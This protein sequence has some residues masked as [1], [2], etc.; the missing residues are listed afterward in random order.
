LEASRKVSMQMSS[1]FARREVPQK[2]TYRR[3]QHLTYYLPQDLPY[4]LPQYLTY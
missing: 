4:Y 3:P 2:L 1:R